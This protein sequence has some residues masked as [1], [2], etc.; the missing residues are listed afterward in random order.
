MHY[1]KFSSTFEFFMSSITYACFFAANKC[2][3]RAIGKF[4][5]PLFVNTKTNALQMRTETLNGKR[6]TNCNIITQ[7]KQ[8]EK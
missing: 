6:Q 7:I 1:Y 5:E 4:D 8:I 2:T 3:V